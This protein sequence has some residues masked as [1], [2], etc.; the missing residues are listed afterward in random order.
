[1]LSGVWA[2]V[3]F[4]VVKS[5]ESVLLVVFL[6]IDAIRE[7]FVKNTLMYSVHKTCSLIPQPLSPLLIRPSA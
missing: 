4:L 6:P 3:E 1:M 2:L 7:T 5:V